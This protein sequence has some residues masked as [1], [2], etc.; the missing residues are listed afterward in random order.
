MHHRELPFLAGIA[1]TLRWIEELANILAGPL[2]TVGLAI[3]LVDLLTDGRLLTSQPGLLYGWAVSH[4]VGVDM[5][6]VGSWD[7]ARQALRARRSWELLGLL[8]LGVALAYVGWVAAQV[9]ALQESQ[10]LTT[11]QALARLG[12]DSTTWLIQ[13]SAL[14]VLLVCLSGWTRYHPPA[15]TSTADERAQLERELELEP[16]RA[17]VRARKALG[18]RDV[19]RA[20]AQ[21]SSPSEP[22][23][24]E[25]FPD[26][27]SFPEVPPS[28]PGTPVRRR[29]VRTRRS[30]SRAAVLR[31]TPEPAEARI[32]SVLDADPSASIKAIAKHAHVGT[33]TASKWRGI[34]L[35][36]QQGERG[37]DQQLAQ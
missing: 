10:G 6:L 21:G 33:S 27:E 4:A 1:G 37:R 16:L 25:S 11:A 22:S 9:F 18:W 23:D 5:Q 20:I 12:M 17:A 36:E 14:S 19:G 2:L 13:R 26:S 30:R 7:R 32:R 8:V 34:V 35:A 28:G 15:A 24:P 31:L 3:A 29:G